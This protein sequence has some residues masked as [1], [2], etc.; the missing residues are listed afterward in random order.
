[1]T[2]AT[3]ERVEVTQEDRALELLAAA[4]DGAGRPITA[5]DLRHR[6]IG[7]QGVRWV[8]TECALSA[9]AAALS[10]RSPAPDQVEV[11]REALTEAA[12]LFEFYADEHQAKADAARSVNRSDAAVERDDKAERNRAAGKKMRA[13]IAALGVS[14]RGL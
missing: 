4:Y 7:S 1:M 5:D 3:T 8:R 12:V 11:V 14:P 9:I 6:N 10:T 2:E 13:A